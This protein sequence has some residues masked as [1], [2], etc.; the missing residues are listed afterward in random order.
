MPYPGKAKPIDISA[1]DE[2]W[3]ETHPENKHSYL[4]HGYT[5]AEPEDDGDNAYQ[6]ED[7]ND[8]TEPE[9]RQSDWVIDPLLE[10]TGADSDEELYT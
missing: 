4:I 3:L 5:K 1:I 2:Q 6:G 9:D 8:G 7:E 10:D